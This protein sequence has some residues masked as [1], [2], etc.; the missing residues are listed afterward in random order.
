MMMDVDFYKNNSKNE[1]TQKATT[2]WINNYKKWAVE[3]G[4]AMEIEKLTDPVKLNEILEKY[5]CT[6]K[7]VN[8]KEYETTTL[9]SMQAGIDRFLR[10][11]GS[12]ISIL[13]HKDLQ[14]SR[15][16]LDGKA[17]FLRE[18]LGMGKRPNAAD[19]LTPAEEEELWNVKNYGP[20]S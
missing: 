7:K 9:A 19:S 2:S 12:E 14:G 6:A 15:D 11:N 18:E 4:T 17:K 3:N 8:G 20:Q 5:F 13:N 16:V 1:N 10:E